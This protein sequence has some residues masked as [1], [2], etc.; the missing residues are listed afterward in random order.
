MIH[1]KDQK[2]FVA[3]LLAVVLLVLCSCS[4]TDSKDPLLSGQESR[5]TSTAY[6]FTDDLGRTVT[7]HSCRRVAALLG[8]YADVW[9]LAGGEICA[10]ADDAFEDF[11][12]PLREGMTNLGGTKSLS[13]EKL[14]ASAPDLVLAS[15][16]TPQHLEW[17]E[18]LERAG[19]TVA[20]FDVSDF[21]DYLRML[22][23]CTEITGKSERYEQYGAA[24]Q[25]EIAELIG[26]NQNRP[27]YRVLVM[28]VSAASIRAKGSTGTVLG[29]MLAD[30]GCI[31]IADSDQSLLENLSAE[32]IAR[33]N[34]D[35]IFL[36]Q[37]GDDPEGTRATVEKLL[38]E[39]PLWQELDAVQNGRMLYMEKH[40]YHLKPNA[41]WA[42]AYRTLEEI[43][44]ANA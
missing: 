38:R 7:V 26:R 30:Y 3:V 15:T 20:Y 27:P 35:F 34:P 41:R 2:Q 33:Q 4:S 25:A 24:Q 36:L 29:E 32:S 42:E 18:I 1:M 37:T 39:Q 19:V 43:L 6:T 5:P 9:T 14:L 11:G 40:L 16:N 10:S 31:N 12:I 22:R 8:S 44:Y 17:R 28:R 21:S 23:I 13:L